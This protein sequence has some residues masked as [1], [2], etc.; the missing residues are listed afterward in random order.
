MSEILRAEDISV[1][2]DGK[3][4]IRGLSFTVNDG[5]V[6]AVLGPNGSGK[7]TLVRAVLSV[8]PLKSGRIVL[9]G[10]ERLRASEAE[11]L[12]G[13]IPQRP[14]LDRTFPISLGEML[15]LSARREA[16]DRY[17][18]MLGLRGLLAK[19]VG[20]LS[21]GQMQRALLA[22]AVV[23]E[24]RLLVM[25]EPTSWVDASGADCLLCLMEEFR[26][27]GIAM[28]LV[29]HDFSVVETVSTKVLGL[30]HEGHFFEDAASPRLKRKIESL[31]GAMHHGAGSR[32]TP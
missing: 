17:V 26:T 4:V 15:G 14:E 31:L 5:D 16:V 24:P 9:F 25:D 27:K 29:S 30:G 1:G 19:K 28:I 10:K 3:P 18:D 7:T 6:V 21:G 13:Y 32:P 2:Y 20:E 23:K 11:R 22:Y 12:I 8:M